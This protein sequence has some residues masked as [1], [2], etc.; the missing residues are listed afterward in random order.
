ME[1]H[2]NLQLVLSRISISGFFPRSFSNFV[3]ISI[4]ALGVFIT[5]ALISTDAD[6][7]FDQLSRT[8]V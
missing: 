1:K 8:F 3:R 6:G 2:Q 7:F 5:G 4:L